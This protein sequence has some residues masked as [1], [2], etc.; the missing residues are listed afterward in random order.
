[1]GG[2]VGGVV[3]MMMVQ[4]LHTN[5]IGIFHRVLICTLVYYLFISHT[6][7]CANNWVINT[8]RK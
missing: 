2:V 5:E 7:W 1:M 3:V 8:M 6:A 4:H